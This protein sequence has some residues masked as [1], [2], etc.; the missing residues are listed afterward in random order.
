MDADGERIP[1]T[2]AEY[3]RDQGTI[4]LIYQIVGY[5]TGKLSEKKVGESLEDF[6]GPL[7]KPTELH[8]LNRVIGIGSDNTKNSRPQ[9]D[10][11]VNADSALEFR[12]RSTNVQFRDV[13]EL[14][15]LNLYTR[16][17]LNHSSTPLIHFE[18][19]ILDVGEAYAAAR[20]G[21]TV[22][23]HVGNT[24]WMRGVKG[25]RGPVRITT[26]FYNENSGTLSV[27]AEAYL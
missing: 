6:V 4:T 9:T 26:M 11:Q 13:K 2:I 1:L 12:L 18:F 25:W 10:P 17:Y 21:N 22:M 15:T 8:R 24:R 19:N 27:S 16:N 23:L 7:G 5:T 20:L 3:D 14:S